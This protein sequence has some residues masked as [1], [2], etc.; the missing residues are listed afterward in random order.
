MRSAMQKMIGI[1]IA[2]SLINLSYSY[3]II[4]NYLEELEKNLLER[5][6]NGRTFVE[7]EEII[8]LWALYKNIHGGPFE[9]ET[10]SIQAFSA[11]TNEILKHNF[12][13]N[14]GLHTYRLGMNRYTHMFPSEFNTKMNGFR[15]PE[16]R[17][18]S[19]LIYKPAGYNTSDTEF[20]WFDESIL[21]PIVDQDKTKSCYAFCAAD[22]LSSLNTLANRR[23]VQVS[24]QELIDC[25]DAFGN[26]GI[27]GGSMDTC[28]QYVNEV[29]GLSA[30]KN[31]KFTA[32]NNQCQSNITRVD[33]P[34]ESITYINEGNDDD[35]MD[36][37][38]N[39]GPIAV[40]I[41]ANSPKFMSYR[42]GVYSND[43]C[44]AENI[45]HAVLLVGFGETEFNDE[46]YRYWIIKNSWTQNWGE[47]GYG[48]ILRNYNNTCGI[49][50]YACF[51]VIAN[52]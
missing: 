28:F 10:S 17:I 11:N 14:A 13:Y 12:E 52:N 41:D 45:N 5:N 32:S 16:K 8:K 1:I 40:A 15:K 23:L 29:K 7:N 33:I 9:N 26:F 22:A 43:L 24:A 37:L 44:S 19:A 30:M 21:T 38:I 6:P 4:N 46:I 2:I 36:A 47:G 50:S 51:P 25:T 3:D 39:V 20:S 31:Y 18:A 49:S 48:K 42:K 35:L 27:N 34:I